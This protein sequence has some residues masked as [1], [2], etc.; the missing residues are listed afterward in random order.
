VRSWKSSSAPCVSAMADSLVEAKSPFLK[1]GATQ[2]VRWLPWG[3][4]AFERARHEDKP[5][6]LDIGAVWCHWCHVMDR[7]SYEDPATAAVINELFV[8]VKVDRDERPDVDARYQRA[9]QSLSGQGGWPLTAFL[10]PD[11]D[12]YYGGT[13][14]PPT[15]KF[16]RPSF[17]RVLREVSRIWRD[18]RAK[19]L[20][21]AKGI[22]DRLSSFAQAEVQRGDLDPALV[23]ATVEDFAQN[24]DFRYGGFGR[25]PKFPNAGG[26]GLLLD[27]DLDTG[28]GWSGRMVN[29]TL[30]AMARGGIY[31]QL[32]GGFHRYSVDARWL[33]PHFEKMSQDNGPLLEVYARAA[34]SYDNDV[35]RRAA[36]GIVVNYD[37]Q[38]PQLLQNGGFPASQDADFSPDDDG[39]YW[40]WT[41]EE[42][43]AA[44]Q[45]E[46]AT[47]LA[48]LHYGLD[49]PGSSMHIDPSRHVLFRAL[50]EDALAARA[51]STPKEIDARLEHIRKRLKITR[52]GRPR[53]FVDET[54]YTGWNGLVASGF[55]AAARHLK[56]P[57]AA[58]TALRA[59]DRIWREAYSEE[60]GLA[61]RL[62]DRE[63]GE[64][65]EDH[66]H[67]A[68]ALVD[69]FEYTQEAVWLTRARSLVGMAER[70]F[71]D[72]R[73]GAYRD[74]PA[75][76]TAAVRA[77]QQ[78]NF[79]VADAPVPAG[80]SV[81]A[82]TLLR[83]AALL[84]DESYRVTALRVLRA[85]AG[86][87]PR[88]GTSAATYVRAL[89]WAT[90]PVTTVVTVEDGSANQQLRAA[91]LAAYRPR[92]VVRCFA[93]NAIDESTVPPEIAAML[94][95][96]AP[97]A[98]ICVGN[99][100][101][102][103]IATA[104][105]L[106]RVLRTTSNR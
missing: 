52:D 65:L 42:I 3:D 103:P 94:T 74:R 100:C 104:D 26:L 86:S 70:R 57:M 59:L 66:A 76:A 1:H 90:M 88:L 101:L 44:L 29:E 84:H 32:G 30:E 79:T 81:M 7:E 67:F 93:A 61:H 71:F 80:N 23:E 105:E 55:I 63:A 53:P 72:A 36:L 82:L 17:Q 34:A 2:P 20:E 39:D 25:A 47:R 78:A 92:T 95:G 8:P 73:T 27:H 58:A 50:E 19:A 83:L 87:A 9:V 51:S 37:D 15:D 35:F 48:R 45:D 64:Y 22:Q 43:A 28:V 77:L 4:A 13:Y 14:F 10:T 102:A 60:S 38:A 89:G 11:G 75:D 16:G 49:D 96:E 106:T 54:V 98:Y 46:E 99:A 68:Q 33:I 6:L 91:A 41:F 31:D 18:E 12:T 56:A 97:R 62:G 69:A 85:F 21:A 24:Y 5:I 40:T